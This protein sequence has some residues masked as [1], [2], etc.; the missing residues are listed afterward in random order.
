VTA[1]MTPP[2]REHPS[3]VR[4]AADRPRYAV[5]AHGNELAVF[6]DMVAVNLSGEDEAV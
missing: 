4:D 6:A 3:P 5:A 2:L 1:F